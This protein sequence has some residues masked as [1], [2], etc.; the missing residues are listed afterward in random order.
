MQPHCCELR[1]PH[2]A[3]AGSMGRAVPGH[4]VVVLDDRGN[5]AHA[6]IEGEIA[7][8]RPDPVMF[9]RYWNNREATDKKFLGDWLLTGDR[10]RQDDEGHFWFVGRADDVITTAGYR[11]GPGE[12]EECLMSIRPWL[13]RPPSEFL[14]PSARRSSKLSSC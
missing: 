13:L 8:R 2:G 12:I 11:V 10:C 3:A 14:T 5:V 1:S 4:D 6:G 7:V 9:L